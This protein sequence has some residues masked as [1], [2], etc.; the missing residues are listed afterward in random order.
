MQGVLALHRVE[1]DLA[2]REVQSLAV[3]DNRQG[4]PL[5][6]YV[7]VEHFC[8]LR[9]CDCRRVILH[10]LSAGTRK[11]LATIHHHFDP[12]KD[13]REQTTLAQGQLQTEHAPA[14]LEAFVR[15]VLDDRYKFRLEDHYRAFKKALNDPAH[16]VQNILPHENRVIRQPTQKSPRINRND[17]CPCGSGKKFKKCHGAS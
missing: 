8:V 2:R 15:N 7:F 12:Q 10:V 3:L 14:L 17:P 11:Q 1:P 13:N 6:T 5:D 4:L 16:P 9:N